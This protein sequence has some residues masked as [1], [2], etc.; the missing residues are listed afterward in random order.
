MAWLLGNTIL[1]TRAGAYCNINSTR[2]YVH[3]RYDSESHRCWIL[4][5]L[6]RGCWC[7]VE[8]PAGSCVISCPN[9]AS[10]LDWLAGA[11]WL[12]GWL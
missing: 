4:E 7:L 5:A 8:L 11:G 2:L 12:V 6:A 10:A 9:S 1:P 3:G